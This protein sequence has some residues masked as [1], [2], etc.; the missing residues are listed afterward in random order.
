MPKRSPKQRK[1]IKALAAARTDRALRH[2]WKLSPYIAAWRADGLSQRQIADALN[3]A[4][5]VVPSEWTDEPYA[6]Q[7]IKEWSQ[8]QVRRLLKQIED[9]KERMKWW[10]KHNGKKRVPV[11]GNG[12]GLFSNPEAAPRYAGN[13]S[14]EPS[15]KELS[16]MT[17]TEYARHMEEVLARVMPGVQRQFAEHAKATAGMTDEERDEY[18]WYGPP[19]PGSTPETPE[20]RQ[21][22]RGLQDDDR[23]RD[24]EEWRDRSKRG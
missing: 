17:P 21:E 10:A 19:L 14:R 5:A 8:V 11:Y 13:K 4:G 2:A 7:P 18:E 1:Q 9:A 15:A 22:R 23:E 24:R 20:Q 12:A 16:R 6:P 3:V